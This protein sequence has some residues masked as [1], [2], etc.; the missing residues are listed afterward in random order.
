[1]KSSI[2]ILLPLLL[3]ACTMPSTKFDAQTQPVRTVEY[4]DHGITV[5]ACQY[6][7]SADNT[8]IVTSGKCPVSA[9]GK[10]LDTYGA[11]G[12]L[13]KITRPGGVDHGVLYELKSCS[14]KQ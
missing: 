14:K 3:T 7:V 6:T 13:Y 12:C 9:D 1:M 8:F 11:D 4:V 5:D 2:T 10:E